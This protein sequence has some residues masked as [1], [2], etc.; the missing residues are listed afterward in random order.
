MVTTTTVGTDLT[1]IAT[2]K[3]GFSDVL[4]FQIENSDGA[5]L[6]AFQV[7]ARVSEDTDTWVLLASGDTT[8]A[9]FAEIRSTVNLATLTTEASG[10]L[11]MRGKAFAE[12]RLQASVA[13]DTSSVTVYQRGG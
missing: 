12:V 7:Q 1:T 9:G 11:W 5:A 8:T 3:A 13:A 4:G 6:N 2:A 10:L